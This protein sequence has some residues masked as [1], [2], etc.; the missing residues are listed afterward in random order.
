MK[1]ET[2]HQVQ[3]GRAA[4]LRRARNNAKRLTLLLFRWKGTK[5]WAFYWA[6]GLPRPR[7][8]CQQAKVRSILEDRVDWLFVPVKP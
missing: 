1:H 4:R 7:R 3:Q 2:S 5:Q 8:D 6:D